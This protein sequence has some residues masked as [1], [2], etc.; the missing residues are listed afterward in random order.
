MNPHPLRNPSSTRS[1]R[2]ISLLIFLILAAA[3][4]SRAGVLVMDNFTDG[5]DGNLFGGVEGVLS[6]NSSIQFI[7]T[8]TIGNVGMSRKITYDSTGGSFHGYSSSRNN[9]DLSAYRYVSFWI[10]GQAGF[11]KFYCLVDDATVFPKARVFSF[12]PDKITTDWQKIVISTEAFYSASVNW[13]A[14]GGAFKIEANSDI[15]SGA[16][17]VYIDDIRFGTRPSP[18]WW[19]NFNDGSDPLIYGNSYATYINPAGSAITPSYDSTLFFGTTG[20]SY[21]AAFTSNTATTDSVILLPSANN[22]LDITGAETL[23]F[24]LRGDSSASGK[25]LGIGLK[26]A[27]NA[28]SVVN[29]TAYLG[30]GVPSTGFQEVRIPFSDFSSIDKTKVKYV[31]VWFQK[32]AG[33]LITQ[34]TGFSIYLD[35]VRFIDTSTPTAPTA[36]KG[37]GTAIANGSVFNST[38]SLTVTADAGSTDPTLEE[39]RFEHDGLTGGA[40]WYTIGVDTD[41]ADT[42]YGTTWYLQTLPRGTSYQIRALAVDVQGNVSYAGPFAVE[43]ATI[44]PNTPTVSGFQIFTTSVTV[45]LGLN[46]NPS[47]TTLAITTGSFETTASSSGKVSAFT[48]TNLIPNTT[49][50]IQARAVSGN[51]TSSAASVASTG[52]LPA[53]PGPISF[54]TVTTNSITITWTANS[55]PLTPPTS[56]EVQVSSNDPNFGVFTTSDTF[57][58][59]MTTSPLAINT[60]YYFRIFTFGV[61]GATSG[62]NTAAS[63]ITAPGTIPSTPTAFGVTAVTTSS[64]SF[65]WTDNSSN[66]DGFQIINSTNGLYG[67]ATTNQTS[68]TVGN[69]NPNILVTARLTAFNGIGAST[70]TNTISTHTLAVAPSSPSFS[71][72]DTRQLSVSWLANGNSTFTLYELSQST[73]NFVFA[74]GISTPVAFSSSFSAATVTVTGLSPGTTYFFRVRARNGDGVIAAFGASNST[75]T[76]RVIVSTGGTISAGATTITADAGV[77]ILNTPLSNGTTQQTLLSDKSASVV[78]G[79]GIALSLPA[80]VE[81]KAVV[82]G[83]TLQ[84]TSTQT[85]PLASGGLIVEATSGTLTVQSS[86]ENFSIAL[87]TDAPPDVQTTFPNS[88]T[89]IVEVSINPPSGPI[90][91]LIQPD[92]F[93]DAVKFRVR[94]PDVFPTAGALGAPVLGVA[95]LLNGSGIGLEILTDKNIQPKNKVLITFGYRDSDVAGK[96]LS[97]M[98]IARFDDAAQKWIQLPTAVDSI[99]RIA[100]ANTNH[101]SKFQLM[102]VTPA[103]DVNQVR[104]FPNPLREHR[105]ETEMSFTNLNAN[106]SIKIYTFEGELVRELNAD[107]TGTARWNAR[108]A[109]GTRVGS[110]VYLALIE[111]NLDSRRILKLVVEK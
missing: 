70:A 21:K 39:V 89:K 29:L 40:S 30:S 106:A 49:Y 44:A 67:S 41:L 90:K 104:V 16:G 74:A 92:T 14:T 93:P 103:T 82:M 87:G 31:E 109:S 79:N 26:D 102:F 85:V 19:D 34:T 105:G 108:N 75:A 33:P 9:K 51:L 6:V 54:P 77:T 98:A 59:T 101:F 15:P 27:A 110:G 73:D 55:N 86:P 71:S 1:S 69:L 8:V 37:N 99:S 17:A 60:T 91:T 58:L 57:T 107:D 84:L 72:V 76:L 35:N 80:G 95:S 96:K 97:A 3:G 25:N 36:L 100:S 53:I 11:E 43:I 83:Q 4:I 46:G 81:A 2:T 18:V 22:G 68:L 42:S 65:S 7:S 63:A 66:E 64:I 5:T 45:T 32:S 88:V 111:G 50:T 20:Y 23:S 10:R 13:G 48:I 94:S 61:K 56:Y 28:E 24:Q 38:V 62:F 47:G 78:Y 52:T 12:V